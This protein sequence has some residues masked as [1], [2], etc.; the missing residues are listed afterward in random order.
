VTDSAGAQNPPFADALLAKVRAAARSIPGDL[1]LDL[2]Y[3]SFGE[4]EAPLSEAIENGGDSL[5]AIAFP[6][7]QVRYPRG[8]IMID[9]GMNSDVDTGY[10][11]WP[12]RFARVQ[13]ALRGANLILMTHEHHD[14]VAEVVR[15]ATPDLIAPKTLLN[16]AQLQTLLERPNKPLIRLT[17]ARARQYLVIDYDQLYPVAAGLVLIKAAGHTPGSQMIYVRLSSG[18]EVLFIGDIVWM[19]AGLERRA[20]KPPRTSQELNEDRLALREQIDW[21]SSLTMKHG[22]IV[23]N[24]H[25]NRWLR[26]LVCQGILKE[27]LGLA[28]P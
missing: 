7:F 14:H 2:R 8:W 21:L 4:V 27:D 17:P 6:V 20:Q 1:P 16:R 9:A 15:T 3:L 19:M 12:K 18:R 25:D 11:F 22:I 26:A 10:T 13:E 28:A 24:S 5:V 23:V